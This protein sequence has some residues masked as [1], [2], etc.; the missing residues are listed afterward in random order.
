MHLLA[1]LLQVAEEVVEV[2]LN[3]SHLLDLT[4]VARGA[5]GVWVARVV[6]LLGLRLVLGR[7]LLLRRLLPGLFSFMMLGPTVNRLLSWNGHFK[8]SQFP[9]RR[10]GLARLPSFKLW[11]FL[12]LLRNPLHVLS[13]FGWCTLWLLFSLTLFVLA[14]S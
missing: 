5:A 14:L 7:V 4:L 13:I 11:S 3:L 2:L 9:V 12:W 8:L 10:N 1:E 6:T